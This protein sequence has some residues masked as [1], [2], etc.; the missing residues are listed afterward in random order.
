LSFDLIGVLAAAWFSVAYRRNDPR[1]LEVHYSLQR[2]WCVRLLATGSWLLNLRFEQL[3]EECV[4]GGPV[5]VFMR[6]TSFVDV[7]LGENFVAQPG[8]YRLR[9]V[10][11]QELQAD[12]A[13][14]IVL[15]RLPNCFVN[16][17]GD[18]ERE[19]ARVKALVSGLGPGDAALIYPE[20]TRF[21]P[22]TLAKIKGRFKETQPELYP[23]CAQLT[24]VLPPRLGGPFAMIDGAPDTDVLFVG[25]TGLDGFDT[26]TSMLSGEIVGQT[27][28]LYFWRAPAA[29]IPSDFDERVG[30]LYKHWLHLDQQCSGSVVV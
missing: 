30:W 13:L 2:W 16:R 14:D 10:L 27:I 23:Y 15:N 24:N 28:R 4:Q 29:E 8:N 7:L 21:L 5:L 25:H 12:P 3:G 1:Y 26:L 17:R 6:H 9:Y 19:R 22:A 11:K 18:S 20:G